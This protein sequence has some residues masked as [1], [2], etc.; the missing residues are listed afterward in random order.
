MM[1]EALQPLRFETIFKEKLWGGEKIKTHLGKDFAPLANCGETWE[2]SGVEGNISVVS[3]GP[4]KGKSLTELIETY[5]GK[6]VGDSI[7]KAFGT[8][9]PLLIKFIDANQDLSIQV[10]PDDALAKEQHNSFGK[11]EMWYIMQADEGAQLIAGFNK[12]TNEKE[13]L[14]KLN[15]GELTSILNQQK[16]AVGDVFFIPA[17]RV[18]TIGKGLLLAEIQQTSDVTY[19]IYDFDRR[20]AEGNKRELHTEEALGALDYTGLSDAKTPYKEQRNSI[21]NL[22]SC[23]YFI[24]NKWTIDQAIQ[25][26]FSDKDSFVIYIA[27][28][29]EGSLKVDEKTYS[30]V[31][32]DVLLIPAVL[33]HLTIDTDS[34]LTTLEVFMDR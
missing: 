3:D 34:S 31:K 22:V 18:H 1:E 8:D 6:L 9:F 24:T 15:S 2:L 23:P 5:R 28:E 25:R 26:D 12:D 27:T 19:R 10:H 4:Q 17:G 13:Y 7:Y 20:D 21:T 14:E 30:L 29:G 33:D 16:V 11:T 32:G